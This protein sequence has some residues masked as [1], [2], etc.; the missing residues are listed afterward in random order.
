MELKWFRPTTYTQGLGHVL[1]MIYKELVA[2]QPVDSTD[3]T[4]RRTSTGIQAYV[5]PKP[6]SSTGIA[7]SLPQTE[8]P[9]A[10]AAGEKYQFTIIKLKSVK[11]KMKM[12]QSRMF[13]LL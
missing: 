2:L 6:A 12:A 4:W 1:G 7:S 10:A 3:V 5:K 8:T 9:K 13:R 11:L